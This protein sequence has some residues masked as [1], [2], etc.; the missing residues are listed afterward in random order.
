MLLSSFCKGAAALAVCA[1]LAA[2]AALAPVERLAAPFD[3]L[4]RVAVAYDGRAFSSGVRWRHEAGRDEIWLLSPAGQ[5]LAHIAAET[6]GATLTAAD[7]SE[8]R[9]SDVESLTRRALGWELPLARLAWWV[10]GEVA[11]GAAPQSVER[12]ERERIAVLIQDGWRIVFTHYSSAEHGGLP[13]R[14]DLSSGAQ[15]IRLLIDSWREDSTGRA[16]QNP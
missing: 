6:G 10:R 4:G 9:A 5:T 15:E 11:P 1:A 16:R 12:D 7:R 8:Y 2:C 14:L 13:R 3:L